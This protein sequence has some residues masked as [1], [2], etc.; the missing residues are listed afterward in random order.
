MTG[1][2]RPADLRFAVATYAKRL[3]SRFDRRVRF[4]RLVGSWARHEAGEDTDV[5]VAA[6]IEGLTRDEWRDAVSDAVEVEL[7]TG[8]LLSPFVVSGE[9]LRADFERL[10]DRIDQ[11][12]VTN[13]FANIGGELVRPIE[14]RGRYRPDLAD[15]VGCQIERRGVR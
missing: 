3:S 1:R 13:P 14:R 7:E 11:P 9:P 12:G 10:R 6:V 2:A 8:A 4:V 15:P 5:D